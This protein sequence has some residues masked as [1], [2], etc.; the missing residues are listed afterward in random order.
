MTNLGVDFHEAWPIWQWLG[1]YF[2]IMHSY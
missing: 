1:Q 2:Q